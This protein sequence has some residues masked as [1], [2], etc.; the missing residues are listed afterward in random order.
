MIEAL[1]SLGLSR[2]DA[3]VYVY[4]A[5]MGPKTDFSLAKA[6][7]INTQKIHASLRN[8][9]TKGLVTKVGTLFSALPFEE[10]LELLIKKEKKQTQAM[11]EN[12]EELMAKWKTKKNIIK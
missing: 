10:A 12:K 11:H 1:V 4:L 9:R 7:N 3:E 5:K 2:S 8:L 6:F